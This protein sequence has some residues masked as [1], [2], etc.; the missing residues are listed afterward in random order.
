MGQQLLPIQLPGTSTAG[1]SV[2]LADELLTAP[3][4]WT[5]GSN[6]MLPISTQQPLNQIWSV[7]AWSLTFSGVM[8]CGG[9]QPRGLPGKFY[10]GLVR[11]PQPPTPTGG[12]IKLQAIPADSPSIALVWDGSTD[13]PFPFTDGTNKPPGLGVT[14]HTEQLP[15]PLQLSPSDR[16]AFGMW[17]TPANGVNISTWIANAGALIVIDD[18]RG[19]VLGGGF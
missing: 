1:M 5:F 7:V 4:G 9:A 10:A 13:E 11:G 15:L 12:T 8:Y 18:G 14:V 6:F 19:P 2:V 17:L 3:G 16:L